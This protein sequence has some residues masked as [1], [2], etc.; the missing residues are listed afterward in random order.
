[1]KGNECVTLR[2]RKVTSDQLYFPTSVLVSPNPPS[3]SSTRT[4]AHERMYTH[5]CIS[6][7]MQCYVYAHEWHLSSNGISGLT[8]ASNGNLLFGAF[9]LVMFPPNCIPYCSE[10]SL[11]GQMVY[12][13]SN[14][15]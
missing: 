10:P 8:L 2:M 12:T 13:S 5:T 9:V 4:N 6:I 15:W 11:L 14:W 1:M 7:K 3:T